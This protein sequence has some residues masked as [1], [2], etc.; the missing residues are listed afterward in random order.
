MAGHPDTDASRCTRV[1]RPRRGLWPPPLQQSRTLT[2]LQPRWASKSLCTDRNHDHA[3]QTA[4]RGRPAFCQIVEHCEGWHEAG[5]VSPSSACVF[6]VHVPSTFRHE[7]RGPEFLICEPLDAAFP[8]KKPFTRPHTP[9]A[10]HALTHTLHLMRATVM[11][12]AWGRRRSASGSSVSHT[13]SHLGRRRA[14]LSAAYEPYSFTTLVSSAG[15]SSSAA[16]KEPPCRPG[17]SALGASAELRCSV[18][19]SH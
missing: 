4:V 15:L 6:R 17:R 12:R 5:W 3:G 2:P 13:R 1:A 9:R 7:T 16:A 8:P 19:S 14:P 18:W 11:G 10:A